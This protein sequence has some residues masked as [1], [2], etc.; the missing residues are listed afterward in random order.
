LLFKGSLSSIKILNLP[1]NM[2]FANNPFYHFPI[3]QHSIIPTFQL[4]RSL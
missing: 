4:G 1:V 2:N 3:T